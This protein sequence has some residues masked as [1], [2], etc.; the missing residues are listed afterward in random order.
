[1]HIYLYTYMYINMYMY[2]FMFM[3][4]QAETVL[5]AVRSRAWPVLFSVWF[6]CVGW[7]A[8]VLGIQVCRRAGI[9]VI[10]T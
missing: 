7:L 8:L 3:Y 10:C 5:S 2:M 1:M 4:V 9:E 6:D